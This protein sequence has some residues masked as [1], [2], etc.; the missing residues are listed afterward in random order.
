MVEAYLRANKMFVEHHEVCT[1]FLFGVAALEFHL[2]VDSEIDV[3]VL[4]MACS[5]RPIVYTLRIW[6]WTLVRWNLVLQ[7]RKGIYGLSYVVVIIS[8]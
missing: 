5:L 2:F 1:F 6:S 7:A 4:M 8:F 3:F